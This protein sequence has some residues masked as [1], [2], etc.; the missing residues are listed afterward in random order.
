MTFGQSVATCFAKYVDFSG[1]ATR[2]EFWWFFL[3]NAIATLVASM[4]DSAVSGR[5]HLTFG[6]TWAL[7]ADRPAQALVTLGLLLP[8]LAVGARR[9]H[10]IGRT[11]WWQLMA[12]IPCLGLIVL[13]VFWCTAGD[14]HQNRYD[15][16]R[17]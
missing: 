10:D 17:P 9:L 12:L 15:E 5:M 11:G 4:V 14:R 6:T 3:F 1:R 16:A 8:N 13:V 2:P 7:S